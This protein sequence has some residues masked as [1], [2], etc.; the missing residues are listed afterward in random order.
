MPGST[1]ESILRVNAAVL[2]VPD[3]DWPMR[4]RGLSVSLGSKAG[5]A[6]KPTGS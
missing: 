4:F 3:C 5:S 6:V 2:P 1:R